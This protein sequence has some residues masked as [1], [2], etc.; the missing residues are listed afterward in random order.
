MKFNIGDTVVIKCPDIS[1]FHHYD[2]C[3]CTVRS[4]EDAGHFIKVDGAD[5]GWWPESYL[6]HYE[7]EEDIEA[8]NL[9]NIM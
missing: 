7:Y 9:L 8:E 4:M 1:V 3:I 5:D 6:R 2:G